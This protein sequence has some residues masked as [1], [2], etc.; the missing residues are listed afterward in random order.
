MPQSYDDYKKCY[1]QLANS[2]AL[3]D[4]ALF[5]EIERIAELGANDLGE[6]G[7]QFDKQVQDGLFSSEECVCKIEEKVREWDPIYTVYYTSA[8]I[9]DINALNPSRIE[10]AL[11]DFWNQ[12]PEDG[13][14]T[15]L[16]LI[17]FPEKLNTYP[18]VKYGIF[19]GEKT[20]QPLDVHQ[21]RTEDEIAKTGKFLYKAFKTLCSLLNGKIYE[22]RG[23]LLPHIMPGP[24][25]LF[26]HNLQRNIEKN[27]SEFYKTVVK[28]LEVCYDDKWQMQ[29][30]LGLDRYVDRKLFDSFSEW[31]STES[32]KSAE[33]A[34]WGL[35]C[36]VYGKD[37]VRLNGDH[38]SLMDR[39]AYSLLNI[40]CG[41]NR[42]LGILLRLSER[43]VCIS[44]NHIFVKHSSGVQ[45]KAV[46][47]FSPNVA[48]ELNPL[49]EVYQ[50]R[51]ES[52]ILEAKDEV[53]VLEPCWKGDIPFEISKLVSTDNMGNAFSSMEC[54]CYGG[55]AEDQ[56]R[57]VDSM[58]VVGPIP[59][60]YYQIGGEIQNI[61]RGFS[62]GI[63]VGNDSYTGEH[64]LGIHEGRFDYGKE[65][66]MIPWSSIQD[67]LNQVSERGIADV[68]ETIPNLV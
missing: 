27:A 51:S 58:H 1:L 44:C 20:S 32:V 40:E 35:N 4:K 12:L 46:S 42:G 66:R 39:I 60:G 54:M 50:Y 63:Y 61:Q 36:I 8:L 24:T 13:T 47:A 11:M 64:I 43:I 45:A 23:V 55:N 15:T 67:A 34:K 57:W 53:I 62:G 10:K 65:A 19:L 21:G 17:R 68:E 41:G 2:N 56:M 30:V 3:L 9:L 5:N 22:I 26:R 38:S 16:N 14:K 37:C 48:F 52:H 25:S 18:Y 31:T 7:R 6:K 28:L 49:T 33:E 59:K 29:L